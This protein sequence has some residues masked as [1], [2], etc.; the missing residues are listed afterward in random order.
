[1]NLVVSKKNPG[2]I[3]YFQKNSIRRRLLVY[4]FSLI[5][6]PLLFL[7]L[8]S[9]FIATNALESNITFS[10]S[11][12]IDQLSLNLDLYFRQYE[13][14]S[15]FALGNQFARDFFKCSGS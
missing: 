11:G 4:F 12:M 10:S 1:M 8:I 6:L 9:Y 15:L 2:W 14:V 5:I 13:Q 7:G 3:R